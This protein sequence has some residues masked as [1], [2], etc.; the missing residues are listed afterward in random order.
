LPDDFGELLPSIGEA[1][2][3][4]NYERVYQLAYQALATMRDPEQEAQTRRLVGIAHAQ[5]EDFAGAERE[6]SRAAGLTAD[7]AFGAHLQYLIG[8]IAT[9]RVYDM[10][11]A[12]LHYQRGIEV[13]GPGPDDTAERS[14]ERS[15]LLNGQ[16]LVMTLKAKQASSGEERKGLFEKAFALEFEAFDG[17]KNLKGA[18][19]S[20][21]RHNLLANLT[22]LLEVSRRFGEAVTFWRRAFERYL[23]ADSHAFEATFNTRL[24]LLLFK[25]GQHDEGIAMLEKARE[26]CCE[27]GDSF[28]VER[29]Y[30]SAGFAYATT[31]QHHRALRAYSAGVDHAWRLRELDSCCAHLAGILCCLAA[32]GAADEFD[33]LK[34][35]V[36]DSLPGTPLAAR[37]AAVPADMPDLAQLLADAGITLPLPSPKLPAYIPGVDLEG[38]PAQDLNRYLVW[39]GGPLRQKDR[40]GGV[41]GSGEAAT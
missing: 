25:A 9:K 8:L 29:V 34:R 35:Q 26:L 11:L 19:P 23:A 30:L 21:L 16:A 27:E 1:L 20:Y 33:R 32:M 24:G 14:V 2:A 5:L 31:G 3:Y 15:W 39:G 13:L 17:V 6:I 12:L 4:Q 7:P 38:T 28:L 37:L 40:P 18:A 41:P 10:D 22:F 36:L